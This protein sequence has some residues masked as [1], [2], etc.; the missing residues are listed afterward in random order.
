MP[1]TWMSMSAPPY[2][3]TTRDEKDQNR[4]SH[5]VLDESSSAHKGEDQNK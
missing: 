1:T 5:F 3:G 2:G 4:S